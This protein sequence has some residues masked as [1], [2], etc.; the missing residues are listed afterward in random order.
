MDDNSNLTLESGEQTEFSKR[1]LELFTEIM[2][3]E[4]KNEMN[5]LLAE[6]KNYKLE[7]E[8]LKK[9][10]NFLFKLLKKEKKEEKT[11]KQPFPP[12]PQLSFFRK[13]EVS[14]PPNHQFNKSNKSIQFPSSPQSETHNYEKDSTFTFQKKFFL[15]EIK[16]YSELPLF[17]RSH[18]IIE[19][20]QNGDSMISYFV[21]A[22]GNA[23]TLYEHEIQMLREDIRRAHVKRRE[24]VIDSIESLTDAKTE[25]IKMLNTMI[26]NINSNNSNMQNLSQNRT[27][28]F[29]YSSHHISQNQEEVFNYSAPNL[30][31]NHKGSYNFTIFDDPALEISDNKFGNL[32]DTLATTE[33]NYLDDNIFHSDTDQ[34]IINQEDLNLLD[35]NNLKTNSV[36]YFLSD[37]S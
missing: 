8:Q 18:E 13:E 4:L 34:N 24:A 14:I 29:N 2:T 35:F 11:A 5:Q 26:Q 16:K 20:S 12:T 33:T 36:D 17:E 1:R 9:E 3:E 31:Q 32:N 7:I 25:E 27:D 23:I 6:Q 30:S 19:K 15:S 37:F 10:R 22:V 28:A 21:N